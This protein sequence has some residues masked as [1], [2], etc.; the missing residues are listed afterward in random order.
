MHDSGWLIFAFSSETEML[1]IMG[2][3]SYY[4]FGQPL[5]LKVM[6]NFF[7]FQS[8]DMTKVPTWVRFPNLPLRC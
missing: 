2:E 1:E 7:D 6:P 3:G 8:I 5:I 4:V